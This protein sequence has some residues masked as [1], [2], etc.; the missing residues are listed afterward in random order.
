MAICK[1]CGAEIL[2][3][4][5]ENGKNMPFNAA[6]LKVWTLDTSD[7]HGNRLAKRVS[8]YLPHWATCP[9]AASFRKKK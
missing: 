4:K 3:A 7:G 9:G 6:P 1:G 8:S 5:S 2:W